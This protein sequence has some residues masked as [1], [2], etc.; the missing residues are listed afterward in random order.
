MVE[1]STAFRLVSSEADGFP[2]LIVDRYG[3]VLVLQSMSLGIEQL[4]PLMVELLQEAVHPKAIV[5]R[6]DSPVRTLEGLPV[7]KK[8][9]TGDR[10]GLVEMTQG[11]I[12]TLVDVWEGQKTGTYLDQRENQLWVRRYAKGRVLDAFAYQGGFALQ[13]AS[14]SEEVLA[15]E[16]SEAAAW[17]LLENARHNGLANVRAERANAFDRLRALERSGEAFD[18]VVLDP[19]AFAKSKQEVLDAWRGYREI[20][21]RAMRLLKPGGILVSCSCSYQ[22]TDEAFAGILREASRD[23]KRRMRLLEIRTQSRDHPILLT[24][25]E[26]KYLKCL[27]LE[28]AG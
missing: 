6:N 17:R 14:S 4:L 9:L 18:L 12:R 28:A 21:L 23:S 7:E 2:G 8:L 16:D 27:I 11:K 15:I 25:P 10:P 26:S 5:A 19:P 20:N 13:M 22:I 24:H 1:E 3:E